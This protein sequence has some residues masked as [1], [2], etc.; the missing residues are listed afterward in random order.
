MEIYKRLRQPFERRPCENPR[1]RPLELIHDLEKLL[2]TDQGDRLPDIDEEKQ[3]I[4]HL[5]SCLIRDGNS[6]AAT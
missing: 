5:L 6:S 2:S 1:L 4:N 3:L